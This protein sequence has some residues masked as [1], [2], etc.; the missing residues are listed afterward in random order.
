MDAATKRIRAILYPKEDIEQINALLRTRIEANAK[1]MV[2]KYNRRRQPHIYKVG[3]KARLSASPIGFK[4]KRYY[5][6]LVEIAKVNGN[7]TYKVKWLTNGPLVEDV[8]DTESLRSIPFRLLK[9]YK[10][11]EK[12]PSE[13]LGNAFLTPTKQTEEYHS[14][15]NSDSSDDDSSDHG[16]IE[17][18]ANWD[19]GKI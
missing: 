15:C 6:Y 4:G 14:I 13:I 18:N 19:I 7:F 9:P 10:G 11:L 5:E 2:E 1:K 3:D 8:I 16:E 12:E 17:L